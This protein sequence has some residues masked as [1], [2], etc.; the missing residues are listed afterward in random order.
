MSIPTKIQD[1]KSSEEPDG[2][3]AA[4]PVIPILTKVIAA[5]TTTN[6]ITNTTTNTTTNTILSEETLSTSS[7]SPTSPTSSL[8]EDE[9]KFMSK[10]GSLKKKNSLL[11]NR[12]AKRFD[13]AD[14]F[15]QVRS[16]K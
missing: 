10:Y 6:T 12:K 15:R 16:S 7:A 1:I 14:Y 8:S 2:L 5:N 11:V 4:E 13:S 3:I 9:T